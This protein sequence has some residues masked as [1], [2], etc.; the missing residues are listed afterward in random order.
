[1]P[2]ARLRE[3]FEGLPKEELVEMLVSHVLGYERDRGADAAG[4]AAGPLAEI[5]AMSFGQLVEHLKGHLRL[6]ELS[7]FTVSGEHVAYVTDSGI[8]VAINAT[9]ERAPGAPPPPEPELPPD[10][11]VTLDRPIER[12]PAMRERR[13]PLFGSGGSAQRDV[14]PRPGRPAGPVPAK[15]EPAAEE[16]KPKKKSLLEF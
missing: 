3:W 10:P 16:G 12:P 8:E 9:G 6:P 14:A 15:E 1:M 4:P 11:E 2:E 5:T 7:R 13:G